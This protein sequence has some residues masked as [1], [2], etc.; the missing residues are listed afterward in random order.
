[1]VRDGKNGIIVEVEDTAGIVSAV[2]R[3]M[4]DKRFAEELSSNGVRT[5]ADYD[6]SRIAA[7]Y[8]EKLY[9]RVL[10]TPAMQQA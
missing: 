2:E 5:A 3:I 1:L 9:R 10:A 8:E 7:Q 4:G 6:W